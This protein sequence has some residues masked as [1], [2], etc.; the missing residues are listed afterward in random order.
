MLMKKL[1][2]I[3]FCS[4]SGLLF[5]QTDKDTLIVSYF[6][7][8]KIVCLN[9]FYGKEFYLNENILTDFSGGSYT[10]K[11]DSNSLKLIRDIVG[12]LASTPQQPPIDSVPYIYI[13]LIKNGKRTIIPLSAVKR[14]ALADKVITLLEIISKKKRS[15]IKKI[16]YCS[17]EGPLKFKIEQEK[18]EPPKIGE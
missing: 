13:C 11:T 5:C 8:E 17:D 1:T 16:I 7:K 2:L 9:Y 12:V 4:I 14:I 18:F 3:I 6:S 15:T 10:V